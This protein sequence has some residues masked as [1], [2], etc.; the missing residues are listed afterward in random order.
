MNWEGIEVSSHE[1]NA[2]QTKLPRHRVLQLG[3]ASSRLCTRR[4]AVERSGSA[5]RNVSLPNGQ[6]TMMQNQMAEEQVASLRE[7]PI[8]RVYR[9]PEKTKSNL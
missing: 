7:V 5:L 4:R 2:Q 6:L 3:R 9:A 8:P 1:S